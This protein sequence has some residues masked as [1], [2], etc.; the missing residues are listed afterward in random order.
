VL[1]GAEQTVAA[2]KVFPAPQR[3]D[4]DEFSDGHALGAAAVEFA[5]EGVNALDDAD[6]VGFGVEFDRLFGGFPFAGT[7]G[8]DVEGVAAVPIAQ[9]R[10]RDADGP[11]DVAEAVAAG[12]EIEELL[13]FSG[14]MHGGLRVES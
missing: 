5:F 2:A 10:G 11:G 6:Q 12:A 13:G 9:G 7:T 1:D 3:D 4:A 14:G 8:V